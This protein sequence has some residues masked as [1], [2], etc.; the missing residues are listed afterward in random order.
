MTRR[1]RQWG[2][3]KVK[4][5]AATAVIALA[6]PVVAYYE[7]LVPS[8]YADPVGIPTVCFGHTG[9][10]ASPGASYSEA[11][12]TALLQGDL[13]AAYGHVLRCIGVELEPHE[14]AALTSFAFNVGGA[15]F[16]S[17]TLVRL[18]NG[19]APASTWCAQLD[20][21]VYARG[22]LLRGLVRRR[23]AERALC[24]GRAAA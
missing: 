18:A 22:I 5:L 9:A 21:W 24:E 20:R 17:S 3:A 11:E 16:C 10:A 23:A 13:L 15:Q 19:G 2:I 7:G 6:T 4:A 1:L 14:A 12:C 8:T